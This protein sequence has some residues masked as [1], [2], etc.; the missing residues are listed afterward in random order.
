MSLKYKQ[1][2]GDRRLFKHSDLG[3]V[4]VLLVYM[5]ILKKN[6]M[7]KYHLAILGRLRPTHFAS[8][9]K[10]YIGLNSHLEHGLEDSLKL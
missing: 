4:T 1:N 10:R 5:G 7:W 2:Q 3:V 8:S 6:F 9:E